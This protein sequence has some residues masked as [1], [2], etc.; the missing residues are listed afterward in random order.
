MFWIWNDDK[1]FVKRYRLG[2]VITTSGYCS[3]VCH[4]GYWVQDDHGV[5]Q[6]PKIRS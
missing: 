1:I 5:N 3:V 2:L 4:L 6:D